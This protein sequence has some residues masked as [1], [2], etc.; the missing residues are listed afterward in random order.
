MIVCVCI[1]H[2]DFLPSGETIEFATDTITSNSESMDIHRSEPLKSIST[3]AIRM[4]TLEPL[5]NLTN[6]TATSMK[7]PIRWITLKIL[8]ITAFILLLTA[9]LLFLVRRCFNS[10]KRKANSSQTT[11]NTHSIKYISGKQFNKIHIDVNAED[12]LNCEKERIDAFEQHRNECETNRNAIGVE[13]E[14]IVTIGNI[15][16]RIKRQLCRPTLLAAAATTARYRNLDE[17]M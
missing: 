16:N 13:Y 14:Q 5:S 9:V 3:E 4:V 12:A 17:T 7:K 6:S 10:R 8:V 11:S 15:F 1:P 2:F